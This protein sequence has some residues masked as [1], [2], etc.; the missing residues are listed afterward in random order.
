MKGTENRKKVG[1]GLRYERNAFLLNV[2]GL[3]DWLKV[4]NHIHF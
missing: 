1:E 2:N 3:F 4:P